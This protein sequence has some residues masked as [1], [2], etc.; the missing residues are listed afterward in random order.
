MFCD[1]VGCQVVWYCCATPNALITDH[2]HLPHWQ[3]T[4]IVCHGLTQLV[5]QLMSCCCFEHIC[6]KTQ[7]PSVHLSMVPWS[8][9]AEVLHSLHD[10]DCWAQE[11]GT[12]CLHKPAFLANYDSWVLHLLCYHLPSMILLPWWW[13]S[14]PAAWHAPAGCLE[15]AVWKLHFSTWDLTAVF[16]HHIMAWH[17]WVHFGKCF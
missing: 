6:C 9:W 17:L 11:L 14:Q 10:F 15:F 12:H 7:W 3:L 5:V 2:V 8:R 13:D 1:P 4:C 16:I